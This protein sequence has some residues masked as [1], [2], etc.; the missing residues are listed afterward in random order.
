MKLYPQQLVYDQDAI[1]SRRLIR[2]V[3]WASLDFIAI[4]FVQCFLFVDVWVFTWICFG[5]YFKNSISFKRYNLNTNEH[6]VSV[7]HI[8]RYV[9]TTLIDVDTSLQSILDVA[10]H[11][12]VFGKYCFNESKNC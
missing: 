1:R 6:L 3:F 8:G 9:S 4:C 10:L 2:V 7:G 11:L 12:R 5:P